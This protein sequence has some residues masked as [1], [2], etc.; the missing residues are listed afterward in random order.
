MQRPIR[1][2][3]STCRENSISGVGKTPRFAWRTVATNEGKRT[4]GIDGGPPRTFTGIKVGAVARFRY[5]LWRAE[6]VTKGACSVRGGA[7]GD[8]GLRDLT[9]PV[10]YSTK[11]INLCISSIP[12]LWQKY[13]RDV[14]TGFR[15]GFAFLDSLERLWFQIRGNGLD[16]TGGSPGSAHRGS[17]TA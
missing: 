11:R 3:Y 10:V 13:R 16:S 14:K 1:S 8:R 5:G 12:E 15:S 7:T 17:S 9:A 4:S 6:C 2:G